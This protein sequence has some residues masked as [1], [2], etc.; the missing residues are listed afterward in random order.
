MRSRDNK[1]RFVKN[2]NVQ[3][4]SRYH[5]HECQTAPGPGRRR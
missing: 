3:Q 4:Q 5:A 2:G 1:G